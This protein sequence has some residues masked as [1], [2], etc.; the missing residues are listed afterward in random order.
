M[1]TANIPTAMT[2]ANQRHYRR[3]TALTSGLGLYSAAMTAS[4]IAWI[5][6]QI[7]LVN[8]RSSFVQQ[9][10]GSVVLGTI[11]TALYWNDCIAPF[12]VNPFG[13]LP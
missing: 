1:T 6:F 13:M 9:I 11:I 4:Q 2:L 12:F 3:Q 7:V 10:H 5:W 8:Q